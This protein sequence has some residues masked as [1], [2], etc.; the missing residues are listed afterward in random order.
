[1]CLNFGRS[2]YPFAICLVILPTMLGVKGSFFRTV[3]DTPFFNFMSRISYC[4]YLFHG[5]VILYISGTKRYDTYFSITDLYI[6]SLA[7]IVLSYF[8]G[9]VTT[10]LVEMPFHYI[11]QRIIG[12]KTRDPS[13]KTDKD[14]V[15]ALN[16]EKSFRRDQEST[17]AEEINRTLLS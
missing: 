3:L 17:E 16:S 9:L 11:I 10:L 2:L 14:A 5:L 13:L 12:Q 1:M 7:V 8:F 15:R 4:T 6:N